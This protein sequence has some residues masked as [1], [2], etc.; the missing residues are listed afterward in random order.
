[1][2]REVVV[3][4]GGTG[5]GY[6]VA[7]RFAQQGDAVLIT[8]RRPDRVR[9]AAERLGPAVRAVACDATDPAAV[10]ALQPSLP[11][12]V[13]VLVNNAG[14]N[15]EFDRP[16]PADLAELAA[17][18]RANLDA[19]L[20]SAV[21]MTALVA[22]RLAAGGSVISVGSIAADKGAGSYGAAKA[23]LASWNIS[24]AGELGPRGITANVVAPGY[25]AGTEYFRDRLT[26]TRRQHLV[27]ATSTGQAGR[28]GDIAGAVFF[29]ASGDARQ[30]TGQV[31]PVNGG[32][33]PTR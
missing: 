4:G 5:I 22:D 18:W 26:G 9:A 29:L 19:N 30:I 10:Q 7:A 31:L 15:I 16:E 12:S 27:A 1:M 3:T 24:L 13:D 28:P 33:W 21:L 6:A 17:S 23:A 11:A 2:G 14:G 32:A 25:T 8:G 20:V